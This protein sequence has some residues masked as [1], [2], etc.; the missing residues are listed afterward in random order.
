[1]CAKGT[2][3]V[4]DLHWNG[5]MLREWREQRNISAATLAAKLG[6]SRPRLYSIESGYTP[7]LKIGHR[8]ARATRGAIRY[9]DMWNSFE[10]RY[11]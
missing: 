1:M 9:R 6:I 10:P 3:Q 5:E 8:I 4:I 2:R 11:A 7:T